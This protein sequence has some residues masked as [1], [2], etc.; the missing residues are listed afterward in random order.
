MREAYEYQQQSVKL[1]ALIL[2]ILLSLSLLLGPLAV[3]ADE[4]P[5]PPLLTENSNTGINNDSEKQGDAGDITD[6][7]SSID[8][9][10]DS[11]GE[12]KNP[13]QPPDDPTPGPED[14]P[15]PNSAEEPKTVDIPIEEGHV[16][17]E[18]KDIPIPECDERDFTPEARAD[19]SEVLVLENFSAEPKLLEDA[20]PEE[21]DLEFSEEDDHSEN[22]QRAGNSK[23]DPQ[24]IATFKDLKA[25]I[26]D[27]K[28]YLKLTDSFQ[29]TEQLS[30]PQ[31]LHIEGGGKTL[32][33]SGALASMF[34]TQG[35]AL[36]LENLTLDGGGQ[37]RHIKA[38]NADIAL[39]NVS[40]IKGSSAGDLENSEG[41][42]IWL[43]AKTG[44]PQLTLTKVTLDANQTVK[45]NSNS[46]TRGHGGAIYSYYANVFLINCTVSNNHSCKDA[47]GGAIFFEGGSGNEL[48]IS[49]DQTQFS[50]NHC[51]E[52]NIPANQ[53][54]AIYFGQDRIQDKGQ[55]TCTISGGHYTSGTPFNTGGILRSW[56]GVVNISGAQFVIPAEAGYTYG[57]S[58]GSICTEGSDL[59]I[60]SCTFTNTGEGKGKVIHAGGLVDIVGQG[61]TSKIVNC[62]FTGRGQGNGHET[63]S[64]GGAI[65]YE[66]GIG[67]SHTIEGCTIT[68]F[69]SEQTGGAIAI[70]SR[71]G[72]LNY[73]KDDGTISS[74]SSAQVTIKSTTIQT[75]QTLFWGDQVG[76]AIYVGPGNAL[77]LDGSTINNAKAGLGGLIYNLGSTTIT[78]DSKLSGGYVHQKVGA[79]I[80]NAGYLKLDAMTL[81]G[82]NKADWSTNP[83]HP[84]K[85]PIEYPGLNVY[86]AEDVIITPLAKLDAGDVRVL[87][88]QSA[89]L[90]TGALKEQINVS[91][92]ETASSDRKTDQ[93][94]EWN[95][96]ATRKLGYVVAK[97]AGPNQG[98]IPY[99]PSLEDAQFIHYSTKDTKQAAEAGDHECTGAWDFVLNPQNQVVLGQRARM[100]Y[101]GNGTSDAQ[102]TFAGQTETDPKQGRLYYFY[103][104]ENKPYILENSKILQLSSETLPEKN[105]PQRKTYNFR[106]WYAADETTAPQL[107]NLPPKKNTV[108]FKSQVP[109]LAINNQTPVLALTQASSDPK[110]YDFTNPSSPFGR[111]ATSLFTNP[112][113][114][115]YAGW[116]ALQ[117][118]TLKKVWGNGV[119]E[120][121]KVAITL[122]LSGSYEDPYTPLDT[123]ADGTTEAAPSPAPIILAQVDGT[124]LDKVSAT[125]NAPWKSDP[126]LAAEFVYRYDKT[127]DLKQIRVAYQLGEDPVPEGMSVTYNTD[128]ETGFVAKNDYSYKVSYRVEGISPSPS[129]P[130]PAEKNYASSS[131]VSVEANLT[132]TSTEYE[133]KQGTWTFIG[134]RIQSPAGLAL[135]NGQFTMPNENVVL[136][137]SWIFTPKPDPTPDPKPEPQPSTSQT[138]PEVVIPHRGSTQE[139]KIGGNTVIIRQTQP[140]VQLPA[141]QAQSLP[142]TGQSNSFGWSLGLGLAGL[143]LAI[144]K[145]K[146]S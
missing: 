141:T 121:E 70:G 52:T 50:G 31:A 134:W 132:T 26:M 12:Q 108:A 106:G 71:K 101:H 114:H 139:V 93:N 104:A 81:S 42:S 9:P 56:K 107:Q 110:P 40:L 97:G 48:S 34:F 58:G 74:D 138:I 100:T 86:A 3:A 118:K 19:Q 27:G 54:G 66:T 37:S 15:D 117:E 44:Q 68:N 105:Y 49:G 99:T 7:D 129:T 78:G 135:Q 14:I 1:L 28:Q 137:G 13:A 72:E 77:I 75:T 30:I 109:T 39:T 126:F 103:S 85:N 111:A 125:L 38:F 79:G 112:D 87:D 35:P 92:S 6:T 146:F 55:P 82:N 24:E 46:A 21:A 80:Y 41:G 2:T 123:L 64:F 60:N 73:K 88:G 5:I 47:E 94:K 119:K 22:A 115:V 136:L 4:D 140:T 16:P 33:A 29:V 131:L 76:G 18:K 89:I 130:V 20:E 36:T 133:G 128:F 17:T 25:A 98:E 63:A 62:T 23:E 61:S 124:S 67:G 65:C 84:D 45:N 51:F 53:G 8:S 102:V 43:T 91:I 32:T 144:A 143:A 69:S 96:T 142:R 90:L 11:L 122:T 116:E 83:N 145:K 10:T 113:V 120:E 95:E 59:T 127:N 57:I